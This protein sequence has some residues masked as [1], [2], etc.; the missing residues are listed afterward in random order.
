VKARIVLDVS[1]ETQEY[2]KSRFLIKQGFEVKYYTG[3]G[4]MHNKFAIIDGKVLITGSFNWTPTADYK[5]EENLLIMS[6]KGLIKKYAERFE[7][8]W[9]ISRLAD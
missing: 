2:S 5:N 9:D 4:L 8:L 3:Q 6:N 7:Y 1:Q